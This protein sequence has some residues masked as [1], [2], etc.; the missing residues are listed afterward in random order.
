MEKNKSVVLPEH[1]N[2]IRVM[3]VHKSKGLEFKVV[4]LPFLSW[5]LDHKSFQQNILWVRPDIEPFNNLGIVPVRYKKGSR[6]NDL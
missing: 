4:L 6:R 5:N 1:L 3:T 2:A